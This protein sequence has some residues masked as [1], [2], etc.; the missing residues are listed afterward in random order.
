MNSTVGSSK[1]ASKLVTENPL[2]DSVPK[3]TREYKCTRTL[4][5]E[6][7]KRKET[8][9]IRFQKLNKYLFKRP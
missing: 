6:Q 3:Q 7:I 4:F 5:P 9:T 2:L 1:N 8:Y